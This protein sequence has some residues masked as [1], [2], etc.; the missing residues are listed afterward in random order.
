MREGA[1]PEG[2]KPARDP[3]EKHKG[4]YK[5]QPVRG[6]SGD[7]GLTAWRVNLEGVVVSWE[8]SHGRDDEKPSGGRFRLINGGDSEG[9][10]SRK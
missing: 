2:P 3:G 7:V 4:K 1:N 6:M 8:Q 5:P 10:Q 9:L